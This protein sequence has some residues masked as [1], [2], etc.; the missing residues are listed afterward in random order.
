MKAV[1]VAWGKK[2]LRYVERWK[3]SVRSVGLV[4]EVLEIEGEPPCVKCAYRVKAQWAQHHFTGS[5]APVLMLDI[6]AV[7]KAPP[8]FPRGD[9]DF[10]AVES[11]PGHY[12]VSTLLIMPTAAALDTLV[13][14]ISLMPSDGAY[15]MDS[16]M[17]SRAV[18]ERGAKVCTLGPQFGWVDAWYR[19]KHGN[20]LPVIEHNTPLEV[21]CPVIS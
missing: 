13:H 7:F 17:F 8:I 4:P 3:A 14:W 9:Y 12:E 6:D 20:V 21:P 10:A 19:Q 15:S 2:Y 18:I 16:T 1:S 5:Q 11:Y